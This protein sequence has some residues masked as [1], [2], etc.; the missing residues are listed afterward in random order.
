LNDNGAFAMEKCVRKKV[1][2]CPTAGA[3]SSEHQ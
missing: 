2:D 3:G 1:E